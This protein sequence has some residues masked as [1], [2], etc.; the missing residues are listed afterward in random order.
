MDARF[1]PGA[2]LPAFGLLAVDATGVYLIQSRA[3]AIFNPSGAVAH[4]WSVEGADLWTRSLRAMDLPVQAAADATGVYLIAL[5]P[6]V[7]TFLR[8]YDTAGSELWS[9][10]IEPPP[11]PN[12]ISNCG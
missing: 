1:G 11:D 8:K 6:G 5:D 7:G 9:R 10:A 2:V 3:N 4:K 12:L